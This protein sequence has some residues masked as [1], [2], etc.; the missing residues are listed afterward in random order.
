MLTPE[1]LGVLAVVVAAGGV[2]YALRTQTTTDNNHDT[3]NS[4][5]IVD[6]QTKLFESQKQIQWLLGQ[7]SF[8]TEQSRKQEELFAELRIE[9]KLLTTEVER[10]RVRLQGMGVHV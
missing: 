4:H 5:D 2:L 1:I 7:V 6:L 10:L 9:N 3:D 8:L